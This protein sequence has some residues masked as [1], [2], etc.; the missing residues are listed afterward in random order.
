M[1]MVIIRSLSHIQQHPAKVNRVVLTPQKGMK[2]DANA[3][4]L[5]FF[6]TKEK[7]MAQKNSTEELIKGII[8]NKYKYR[9]TD[10]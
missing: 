4:G 1:L 7:Q 9:Y 8:S 2:L 6:T 3:F 5:E 10:A